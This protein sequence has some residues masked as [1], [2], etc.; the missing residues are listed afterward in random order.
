[1][2]MGKDFFGEA[3]LYELL[4]LFIHSKAVKGKEHTNEKN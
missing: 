2:H 1:M 4:F 3:V